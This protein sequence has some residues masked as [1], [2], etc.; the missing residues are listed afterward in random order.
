MT[1]DYEEMGPEDPIDDDD[2]NESLDVDETGEDELD[3]TGLT[4]EEMEAINA[5]DDEDSDGD[6]VGADSDS[7]SG[8]INDNSEP[9]DSGD[10]TDAGESDLPGEQDNEWQVEALS[11]ADQRAELDTKF[12]AKMVEL[13]ALGKK[14]DEGEILDGAYTAAKM[15]IE[16]EIKRIEAQEAELL[17]KEAEVEK[18]QS[19]EQEAAKVEFQT[20]ATAFMQRPENSVFIEGSPE[21]VVLDQ[22][23]QYALA[24]MPA[25]TPTAVL[26]E[27]ARK[28]ASNF[29]DLPAVPVT[30]EDKATP[31]A[32][33]KPEHGTMPSIS[34]MP[35]VVPNSSETGKYGHLDKLGGAELE[36]TIAGMTPEQQQQ[37]L[38]EG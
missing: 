15:R 36:D 28:A 2:A 21:F 32:D 10:D 12:D 1:T 23:Y 16:R 3:F 22:Q 8:D 38:L 13:E 4:D 11:I 9:V 34:S 14:Y 20:A 31:V 19:V 5:K 25:G 6:D 17:P 33:K 7:D 27:A 30:T 29:I 24:H 26:L 37:Y 18:R 35:S